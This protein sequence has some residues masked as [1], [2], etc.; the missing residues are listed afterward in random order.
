[1][2]M[3]H[4]FR[5][6]TRPLGEEGKAEGAGS[7]A[8]V[9]AVSG[10][11]VATETGLAGDRQSAQSG[12]YSFAGAAGTPPS[13]LD[14]NR[15]PSQ[16]IWPS[17]LACPEAFHYGFK[18]RHHRLSPLAPPQPPEPHLL[19]PRPAS[20]CTQDI[21]PLLTSVFRNL[22]TAEVLGEDVSASLI[23]ARGSEDARH[24]QFVD[25]LQQ[26]TRPRAS[27]PCSRGA[28]GRGIGRATVRAAVG[29]GCW[30]S[31]RRCSRPRGC[32][33]A[34]PGPSTVSRHSVHRLV[35]RRICS[36][37]GVSLHT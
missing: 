25:E 29:L 33:G 11:V 13:S 37:Y 3:L 6:M 4:V 28:S 27:H 31:A 9:L 30:T 7:E 36:T 34:E 17:S 32:S 26:V 10:V 20:L 24:E 2:R 14:R 8:E 21:S 15:S 5:T 16:S 12:S 23:K 35:H 22:Y 19:R 18:T 1:M